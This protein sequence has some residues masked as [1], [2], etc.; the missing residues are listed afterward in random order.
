MPFA[1]YIGFLAAILTTVAYLP[2]VIKTWKTKSAG[3][4]SLGL[5]LI[6]TSGVFCWLVYGILIQNWP[7]LIAN[8]ITF[9]LTGSMLWFKLRFK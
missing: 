5:F 3:D 7:I 1:E 2:Q 6:L 4:L 8:L 9:L